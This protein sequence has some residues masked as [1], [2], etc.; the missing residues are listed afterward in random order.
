MNL[1]I[2]IDIVNKN[3]AIIH[4]KNRSVVRS[5]DILSLLSESK[6]GLSLN[7]I[8]DITDVPK[9]TA[10]E[11]LLML[12]DT[13]MIQVEEGKTKL[14]KI[15]LKAFIIGNRYIQ[16]MDLI[17]EA[18]PI[19]S[20]AS[21]DL[22]MTVFIAMLDGNQIIYLHKKEPDNVPIYTANVS[23]REDA[24][25]TSLGKAILSAMP[26][27]KQDELIKT[28]KFRART[29]RTIMNAKDLKADLKLTKE[30]GYSLDDREILDFV[31]CLGAPIF[32]H[33]GHVLA[34]ISTAGLYSEERNTE[35]EGQIL[36]DA[37]AAIS[38]RLGYTGDF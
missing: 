34:G 1:Y 30:R 16:N 8:V 6:D 7:E 15:G 32:D 26:G 25:C 21:E 24:Y 17:H 19:V 37:A 20:Q 22:N 12:L 4:M 29:S 36:K 27:S 31:L 28:M 14:Y 38:R 18:K 10:Y 5:I 3:G 33:K 35:V 2:R 9:T 13:E 23:N 11:I